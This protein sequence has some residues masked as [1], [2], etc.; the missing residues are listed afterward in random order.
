MA[1]AKKAT[2]KKTAAKPAPKAPRPIGAVAARQGIG[3]LGAYQLQVS[4]AGLEINGHKMP[5]ELA[6]EAIA[7]L[8]EQSLQKARP[9]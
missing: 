7:T 8:L 4:V 1:T 2:K 9:S 3:P 5:G 6:A